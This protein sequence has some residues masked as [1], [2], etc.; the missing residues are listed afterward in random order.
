[1]TVLSDMWINKMAKDHKMIHPFKQKQF[2]VCHHGKSSSV[3][4]VHIQ[5]TC[6]V[7]KKKV[8]NQSV[9]L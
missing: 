2:D 1:M 8:F 5:K 4:V 9:F 3:N 7:K 6:I